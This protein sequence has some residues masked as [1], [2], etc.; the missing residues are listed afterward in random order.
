VAEGISIFVA[1]GDEG[2]ASC[3]AGEKGATHG[4]GVSSFASTPYNAAVGGTDFGDTAAG[5]NSSY[6]SNTNSSAFASALSYIPEIC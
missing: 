1:A 6:W 3:D 5:T 4:I 2:A